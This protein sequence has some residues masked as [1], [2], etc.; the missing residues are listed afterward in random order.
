MKTVMITCFHPHIS[1]NVLRAGVLEHILNAGVRI[2]LLVPPK[3]VEYFRSTFPNKGIFVEGISIPK[4][5]IEGLVMLFAFGL[6][7]IQNRV[8]REWK[9]K[10]WFLY[11]LAVLINNTLAHIHVLR[12]WLRTFSSKFLDTAA[13]DSLIQKYNPN[14]IVTTDTFFR[15]DRAI[16]I[17]AKKRRIKT[18]GMLRSWDNATTK[19]LFLC[20][21]D[22]ITVP[23]EIL[24]DEL[25]SIHRVKENS[26]VVTGWPHYD[27]VINKPT[28]SRKAFLTSMGLDPKRKTILY[29]PGG[30]ILYKHDREILSML[31]RLVDTNAFEHPVQFLV[32]L[33]PS[34]VLD[35]SPIEG[36]EHFV[37]DKPGTNLTGRKKD[38][39]ISLADQQHLENSLHHADLVLTLVSTIALD[40]AFY[41][42]PVAF[43]AFDAPGAD[44]QS[45][46]T[47]T[48]RLHFK[49][50]LESGLVDVPRSEEE[51]VA[52]I[53]DQLTS[54]ALYEEKRKKLIAQYAY[55][56][57]GKS[58]ERVASV[59]LKELQ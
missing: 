47:L 54:P 41:G 24:K 21:P 34:D 53:D 32:R 3:K 45:V 20:E 13:L 7:N 29:A 18:V 33:P 9:Q 1:R 14:L 22:I 10:K 40:G 12:S 26:I 30:E 25:V 35:T 5:R 37:I 28:L 58:S 19:G 31:K 49:K 42:K 11:A 2:V 23:N 52:S 4:K 55:K 15:E 59:I 56:L 6:F 38:S 51:L 36:V 48:I 50:L 8:V 46:K 43:I 17:T 44:I 16:S 39:E 57:D 27:S